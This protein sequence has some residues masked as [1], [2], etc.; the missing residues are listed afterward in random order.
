MSIYNDI[1]QYIGFEKPDKTNP[2]PIKDIAEK[3]PKSK[4]PP[5]RS[6]EGPS[7]PNYNY[8]FDND[9]TLVEP[10][11]QF[12]I[13][14]LIR[15][16]ALGNQSVS[17]ALSNIVNLANTGHKIVFDS[18]VSLEQANEMREHI[19]KVIP[20]WHYGV[21]DANGLANKFF[22]Q[23]MISG[24]VVCEIIPNN[25]LTGVRRLFMP[26]PE[27]IRFKYNKR[28]LT[29]KPY[30]VSKDPLKANR[31]DGLI[32][33]NINA[34]RYYA[35]NGDT[36]LPYANPPYCPAVPP[37]HDQ[38]TM[39]ENIKWIIQQMG[40]VGFLELLADK[41]E[42][43]DGESDEKYAGRLNGYL[44]Q[45]KN[46]VVSSMR[47]GIVVGFKDDHDFEFHSTAKNA[48]GV[49]ELF[50]MNEL[51]VYSGL[52]QDP[53]LAGK[54]S[55]G[56]ETFVTVVFTKLLAEL[57]NVQAPVGKIFEHAYEL[58][59]RLRGYKFK[60][61]KVVFNPSTVQDDLK[62][63]QAKEI[64]IRNAR[65]LRMDGVIDQ[66][67]YADE[68]GYDKPAQ[69]EPVVPFA[70]EKSTGDPNLDAQKKAVREKSKDKSDRTVRDKNKPQG[71]VKK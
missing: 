54:G 59:F 65:Q 44:E 50:N 45:C 12:E 2:I 67:T 63:Q 55:G 11:Y 15:K 20:N 69:Q 49:G 7:Q 18:S 47:D 34:F 29:Y 27:T 22:S 13:I 9:E 48:T 24:A 42:Q 16:L 17:Q 3:K 60:S 70:P 30:Q 53:T 38:K 68:I 40:V 61:L 52:K 1:L 23:A 58:E 37:L 36:E 26:L 5:A 33:L 35:I 46:S 25:T 14:P 6:S 62:F 41:P 64:K 56:A 57:K 43:N 28:Q 71:T 10:G 19:N 31:P 39:L 66:D 32:P 8:S 4:V 21:A 51:L